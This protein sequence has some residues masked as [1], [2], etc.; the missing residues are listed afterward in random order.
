MLKYIVST[1]VQDYSGRTPDMFRH[2]PGIKVD[3]A[4]K[5]EQSVYAGDATDSTTKIQRVV[6]ESSTGA[7]FTASFWYKKGPPTTSAK[8]LFSIFTPGVGPSAN[9]YI[10]IINDINYD[11]WLNVCGYSGNA[12][13]SWQHRDVGASILD[14]SAWYHFVYNVSGTTGTIY[15]NGSEIFTFNDYNPSF[16]PSIGD[17]IRVGCND[18]AQLGNGYFSEFNF[19]DGLALGPEHFAAEKD[20]KWLP[21]KYTGEYG[22]NGFYL[23]F[24]NSDSIGNDSSPNGNDFTT[25]GLTPDSIVADTPTNN[26]PVWNPNFT[27]FPGTTRTM[28]EGNLYTGG[29]Q[30]GSSTN[31]H[32]KS[33]LAIPNWGKWRFETQSS[34]NLFNSTIYLRSAAGS[35][36]VALNDNNMRTPNEGVYGS[37]LTQG[38]VCSYAVDMDNGLFSWWANGGARHNNISFDN[39]SLLYVMYGGWGSGGGTNNVRLNAGQR[40]YTYPDIISDEFVDLNSQNMENQ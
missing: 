15:M 25:T 40:S 5:V 22:N 7:D 14:Y 11:G 10:E 26:Y 30:G 31:V 3:A 32:T 16:S 8:T 19:I 18:T 38:V 17:T 39:S 4:Y 36:V 24:D 6:D 28:S 20:D 2:I 27:D 1:I 34:G 23:N 37:P 35:E 33:T 29:L 12:A 9:Q 21:T 13:Y